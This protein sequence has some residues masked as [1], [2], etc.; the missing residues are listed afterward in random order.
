VAKLEEE[1]ILGRTRRRRK[2]NIEMGL[3]EVG[4]GIFLGLSGSGQGEA[5]GCYTVMTLWTHKVS[6][7]PWLVAELLPSQ[8]GLFPVELIMVSD[9]CN[10]RNV[11]TSSA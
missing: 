10:S 4:W 11:N 1:R 5:T 6:E 2:G 8:K 7:I 3:Q 9:H